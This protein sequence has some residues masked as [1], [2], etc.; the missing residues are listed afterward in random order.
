MSRSK[1]LIF[2]III[3]LMLISGCVS[4]ATYEESQAKLRKAEHAITDVETELNS[5]T[6]SLIA[7]I[8]ELNA[9]KTDL[10]ATK[11][12]LAATASKL[13]SAEEKL[14]LYKDTL[15]IDISSGV[16]P[17]TYR[18]PSR[19]DSGL[20]KLVANANASN[21][22]WQQLKSFL[23]T[24]GTS[25]QQYVTGR[26]MC[27]GFA[28]ML[29]NH[30][31]TA[32]IR[33]ALVGIS[34]KE[35]RTGHALNAFVTID[36]GLVYI[37]ATGPGYLEVYSLSKD[38]GLEQEVNWTKVAYVAK[39]KEYGVISLGER[40]SLDYGSYLAM[41]NEWE[42]YNRTVD[43]YNSQMQILN[44]EIDRFNKE[45]R[46]KVYYIGTAED[47]RISQWSQNLKDRGR[48]LDEQRADL[49]RRRNTLET[50]WEPLGTVSSIQIY[51]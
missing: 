45:I 41:K 6:V 4:K 11:L 15:G 26:F 3:C 21:P 37:D 50:V 17:Q 2:T 27:V 51:W 44:S 38:Q 23:A 16:Q 49:N 30:A 10:E 9:I 40:T 25:K 5:T 1:A 46:G 22:S 39:G 34:F 13:N 29:Q 8:R 7:A 42:I 28:E 14:K 32:G 47:K 31:A 12:K 33:A 48:A 20:P 19:P 36:K 43:V 18:V 35:S 24:D